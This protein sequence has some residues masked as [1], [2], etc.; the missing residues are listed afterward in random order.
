VR[1][2]FRR[3]FGCRGRR[4]PKINDLYADVGTARESWFV[5]QL[6]VNHEA[7]YPKKG[8]VEVD[9]KW[10]FEIGGRGKGFDQIKDLPNSYVVNDDVEVGF[11]NKI[12]LWLF[13]FLY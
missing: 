4:H 1:R 8:D 6:R 12:P 2:V 11:G 10:L 13:G 5:N 9:G 7:L 3:F